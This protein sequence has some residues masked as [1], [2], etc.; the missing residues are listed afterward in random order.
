MSPSG[1][2]TATEPRTSEAEMRARPAA[3]KAASQASPSAQ[4]VSHHVVFW[5]PPRRRDNRAR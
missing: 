5:M 3:A 4:G 1:R 2:A